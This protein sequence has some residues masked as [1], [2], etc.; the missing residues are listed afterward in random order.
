MVA[1]N[2]APALLRRQVNGG[3]PQDDILIIAAAD[4][5]MQLAAHHLVDQNLAV[6]AVGVIVLRQGHMLRPYAQYDLLAADVVLLQ[7]FRPIPFQLNRVPMHLH[8]VAFAGLVQL[9][10]KEIHLGGSNEASHEQIMRR[11]ENLRGGAHLLDVTVLHDDDAISQGHGFRLIM[12]D[13]N[14]G[15][16]HPLA[17]QDNLRPHL[18]PQLGVQIAQGFVHQEHGGIPHDGAANG[19]PLAL[20]AGEGLGFPSQIL[21]NAQNLRRLHHPLVDFFLIHLTQPQG[22]SHVFIHRDV[23]IE[24]V[25]LEHHGDIPILGLHVVHQAVAD[26]QLSAGDILQARHHP[27]GGGFSAARRADEYDEFL[28][29]NFQIKIVDHFHAIV[30]NLFDMLQ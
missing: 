18:I 17:Q 6:D 14:E 1:G 15:G 23:G 11:I 20:A 27:Q 25:V 29:F 5:Q 9:R 4:V 26:I 2:Q 16:I 21:C 19:H 22:E 8:A 13:I 28:V 24:S 3:H 12:G 10:L 30:I 7:Q